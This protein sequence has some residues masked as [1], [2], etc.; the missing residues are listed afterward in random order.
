MKL[1]TI[2]MMTCL[3]GLDA[4][5]QE[6]T[7]NNEVR[8][9][10]VKAE[11]LKDD[12]KKVFITSSKNEL[13]DPRKVTVTYY[14]KPGEIYLEMGGVQIG[15]YNVSGKKDSIFIDNFRPYREI[16]SSLDPNERKYKVTIVS[17]TSRAIVVNVNN[18]GGETREN[19]LEKDVLLTLKPLKQ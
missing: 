4:V 17:Q 19:L 16:L 8:Y 10:V 2:F 15:H 12:I 1:F 9:A 6:A 18:G 14:A 5:A 7:P 13:T 3:L 11:G